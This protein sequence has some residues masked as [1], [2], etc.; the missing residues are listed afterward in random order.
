[1]LEQD[2]YLE[3]KVMTAKPHQLHLMV[4]EAAIRYAMQAKEGMEA[5]D[6][7]SSH[8]ALCNSRLCS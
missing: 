3:T 8:L 7:E 5:K 1:M 2:Q 4:V 6:L